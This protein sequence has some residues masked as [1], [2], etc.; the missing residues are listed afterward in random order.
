MN[1]ESMLDAEIMSDTSTRSVLRFLEVTGG[2][3][4]LLFDCCCGCSGSVVLRLDL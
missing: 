3:M 2:S 4:F 1:L